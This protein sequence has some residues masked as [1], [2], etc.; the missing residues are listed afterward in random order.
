MYWVQAKAP[1]DL[2]APPIAVLCMTGGTPACEWSTAMDGNRTPAMLAERCVRGLLVAMALVGV[3]GPAMAKPRMPQGSF[4]RVPARTAAAFRRQVWRD[5]AVRA[6][7][8]KLLGIHEP[9]AFAG[10]FADLRL[11]MLPEDRIL[12]VYYTRPTG[13]QGFKLRRVRKGTQVFTSSS[14]MPMF[15]RVCGNPLR[16]DPRITGLTPSQAAHHLAPDFS[17][18]EP[19]D[20]P[21]I[22]IAQLTGPGMQAP[23]LPS[24][25]VNSGPV[26]P[27]FPIA[28]PSYMPPSGSPGTW[29]PSTSDTPTSTDTPTPTPTDG[30]DDTPII[31]PP[32]GG[33]DDDTDPPEIDPTPDE[34]DD[35]DPPVPPTDDDP[36]DTPLKPPA[37][38]EPMGMGMAAAAAVALLALR[39]GTQARNARRRRRGE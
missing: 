25:P 16:T 35:P 28:F 39:A 23:R 24:V 37:T 36:P 9:R 30:G 20:V 33:G 19:I 27:G 5:P 6:R 22:L 18:V 13:R 32:G 12:R 15:V 8:M 10:A 31:V 2:R 34:P 17:P 21:D 7:Y 1:R 26:T 11:T 3:G 4:L 14:G 29:S 38:P